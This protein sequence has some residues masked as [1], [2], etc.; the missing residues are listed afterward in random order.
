MFYFCSLAE[1]RMTCNIVR[2]ECNVTTLLPI[3]APGRD[4]KDLRGV[5]KHDLQ[6]VIGDENRDGAVAKIS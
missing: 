6:I 5:G 1:W 4:R 2:Y 3:I